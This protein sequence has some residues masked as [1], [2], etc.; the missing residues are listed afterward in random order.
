MH[1]TRLNGRA[2]CVLEQLRCV[3]DQ[4]KNGIKNGNVEGERLEGTDAECNA[5]DDDGRTEQGHTARTT[6]PQ[7][8]AASHDA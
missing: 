3:V 2:V 1:S 8:L 4:P 5:H 6:R 7:C